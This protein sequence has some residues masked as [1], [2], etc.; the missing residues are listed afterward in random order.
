[1]SAAA[2]SSTGTMTNR[3]RILATLRLEEVDRLPVWLKMTN[4]TWQSSQPAPYCDMRAEEL[5][6]RAGCDL[7]LDCWAGAARETPHVDWSVT[8]EDGL[9]RT[10]MET[11]D[12]LLVAEETFDCYT[13]SWHPTRFPVQA[14]DDLRRLRWLF[15]DAAYAVAP[16]EAQQWARRQQELE[17]RDAFTIT[18]VGP[19]PLMNMV[20]HVCGAEQTMYLLHD[21]PEL[22][23]ETLDLMHADRMAELRV[24]L[25]HVAADSFWLI[26]NTSTTLISPQL[27]E[28]FCVPHLTDYGQLIRDHGLVAVHH[29]CGKLNALL[30]MIDG[31]PAQVNEAFT[32]P[33]VGDTML[34]DGRARM[35]SKAL[36]GGTNAT[37]WLES[38]ETIV[39]TVGQDLAACPDRRG[40]FLPSAGVLPPPVSFEKASQVVARFKRL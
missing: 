31:L 27:F 12:G 14:V 30:E 3:E 39:E 37:L 28:R 16:H 13:E 23:G 38:V 19:S 18:G 40:I 35:P 7:M 22:F 36:I 32:T 33:P 17:A 9:R 10:V 24:L 5:L 26:E 4:R 11:P 34:A 25:P 29:M 2:Q 8:S 1:M 20:E 6:R 15:E 21:E